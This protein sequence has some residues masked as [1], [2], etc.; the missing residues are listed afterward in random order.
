MRRFHS[1]LLLLLLIG[2]LPAAAATLDVR[3]DYGGSL[4][5][6]VAAAAPGDILYMD[7]GTYTVATTLYVTAG[8]TLQ[9]ESEAGVIL[10]ASA[11]AGYGLHVAGNGVVL[12]NFTLSPPDQNYPIHASGTANPP[13]GTRASP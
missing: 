1:A 12:E 3:D 7:N 13:D 9:G 8:L 11:N 10:D 2:A 6:A 4:H 5:A